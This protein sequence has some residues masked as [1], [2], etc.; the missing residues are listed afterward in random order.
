LPCPPLPQ[1]HAR[2]RKQNKTQ[3]LPQKISP[4]QTHQKKSGYPTKKTET[5]QN[6]ET[7]RLTT[8]KKER[9]D[10]AYPEPV[11]TMLKLK[12]VTP[13]ILDDTVNVSVAAVDAPALNV[14]LCLF[15]AKVICPLA[16]S[17]LQPLVAI[18]SVI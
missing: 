7:Q 17:G 2:R 18:F 16:P 9:K 13:L 14:V 4:N 6:L 5:K 15:Q 1:E 8:N 11:I 12:L 10:R 3:S